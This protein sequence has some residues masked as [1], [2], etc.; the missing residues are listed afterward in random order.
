MKKTVFV[1]KLIKKLIMRFSACIWMIIFLLGGTGRDLLGQA[2]LQTN[3]WYF[4]NHAGLDFNSGVPVPLTNGALNTFEGTAS[5]ADRVTGQL[6]FYTDGITVYDSTHAVMV[7]GN[8]LLG[9]PSSTQSGVIVPDPGNN[10]LY[11]IFAVGAQAGYLGSYGGISY[12]VVDMTLNG[13]LGAITTKNVQLVNPASEKITSVR[14]CNG[15]DVWV[16]THEWNTNAFYCYLVTPSGVQPPV[17]SNTGIIHMDVG[18]GI[19]AESIGYMKVAPDQQHIGLCTFYPLNT[20]QLFDFDNVLG[21]VSNPVTIN[22]PVIGNYGGPY[23]CSFS[24]DGTKFYAAFHN[25]AGTPNYVF[26]YN[27]QAGSPAAIVASQTVVASTSA[28]SYGALQLASDG[29][30]YMATFSNNNLGGPFGSPSIDRFNSPNTLGM[31]CGYAP[32][33]VVLNGGLSIW[34]LPDYIESFFSPP[35]ATNFNDTTIC[36]GAQVSFNPSYQIVMDSV[37]WDFD[38]LPSGAANYST[39]TNPSHIFNVA[40]TY[41]VKLIVHYNCHHD[42]LSRIVTVSDLPIFLGN[43]TTLCNGNAITL[44]PNYPGAVYLWSTGATTQTINVNGAGG[45]YWLQVT[46]GLCVSTDSINITYNPPPVVNLG[47]DTTFCGNQALTLDAGNS[48]SVYTWSTGATTQTISVNTSGNYTVQVN[49]TGCTDQDTIVITVNQPP[50]LFLGND[51]VLCTGQVLSLTAAAAGYTATWSD[52]TTLGSLNVSSGGTYWVQ[53]TNNVCTVTDT[54]NVQFNNPPAVML[55]ND[56]VICSGAQVTL[57]AGN[58]GASYTW[59][60]GATTQTIA[61]SATGNYT[62]TANVSGCIDKDTIQ[63]TVSQPPVLFLGNDTTLCDGQVLQLSAS[64]AGYTNS[65]SNGTSGSSLNVSATGSYWVT[66]TNGVCTVSDSISIQFVPPPDVSLGNDTIICSGQQVTLDAGNAG[67]LFLW[68]NGATTQTISVSATGYY[69]VSVSLA[70]CTDD[71][72]LQLTVQL[73]PP[74]FLGNDTTLCTG[75]QLALGASVAGYQN[76]WSNGSTLNSMT[77]TSAGTYWVQL[78]DGICNIT[79]SINVNFDIPPVVSVGNDTTLCEGQSLTLDAGVPAAAYLWSTGATTQ[80]ISV[81]LNGTYVIEV[82]KGACRAGDTIMVDFIPLLPVELGADT[83][84]CDGQAVTLDPSLAGYTYL[85]STGATTQT[86]TVNAAGLFQVT[87]NDGQCDTRDSVSVFFLSYPVVNLGPDTAFCENVPVFLDAGNPG[88][89]FSWSTGESSQVILVAGAGTYWVVAA[90]GNC[91]ASDSVLVDLLPAPVVD[92]GEDSSLC[93]GDMVVLDAGNPGAAYLWDDG[94]TSRMKT[95]TEKGTYMVTVTNP[96]G[97]SETDTITF[98]TAGCQ[99]YIFI[100]NSFS[101]NQDGKNDYFLLFPYNVLEVEW[102]IF[103]RYGQQIFKS[104]DFQPGWD[105]TYR[106]VKC[107]EDVYVVLVNYS[108]EDESGRIT[109]KNRKGTVLLIR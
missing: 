79:D 102:G 72:S 63:V 57:D 19:N 36:T 2:G 61:V 15:R 99:F 42:T 85:W 101:P 38:D 103:N 12:S 31:G 90:N 70:G 75:E 89:S 65:W 71:D 46:D 56:T 93:S 27:L 4:G 24:P 30:M 94:D 87:V 1:F 69:V 81:T 25:Y 83:T 37:S 14:H 92:L 74:V 26:Q 32:N 64:A 67:A 39:L 33:A 8:G 100:P 91:R 29:K 7:N 66:M 59:S 47:N 21:V 109:R 55:G 51:T 68:S 43:D 86:L 106:N 80:S 35:V 98:G 11:Y 108:G 5:I 58:A 60:T 78:D 49:L 40:G 104:D 54:I 62:V 18:S 9:H 96:N 84:L 45:L 23:G 28:V 20:T 107:Q 16:I 53:L 44:D 41:D 52:G 3:I 95:L 6:L 34:G 22:F 10:N 73:P 97:C 76:L 88:S 77:V 105:G 82:T 48:G 17:I 50:V 13:G